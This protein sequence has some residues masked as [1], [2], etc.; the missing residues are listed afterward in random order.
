MQSSNNAAAHILQSARED[1]RVEVVIEHQSEGAERVALR[2]ST[3]V[4]GLGWCGQK[5]IH[6]DCDELVD[7]Q[8]AITV[9]R[10]RLNRQRVE[11]GQAVEP[12]QVIQLPTIG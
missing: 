7:L 9:A 6:L 12:A 10:R 5:T 4:D 1:R 3:W 8:H 2:Y 11:A